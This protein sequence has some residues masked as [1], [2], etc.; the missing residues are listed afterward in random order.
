[1]RAVAFLA[2]LAGTALSAVPAGAQS[3]YDL[4]Y[5]RNAIY[6]SYGYCFRSSLGKRTFDNS[7]CH[8]RA[9]RLSPSDQRRVDSL[10]R[11]E[12]RRGC[13]VNR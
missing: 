7:D 3:C 8:T 5:E 1:M 12:R 6:D 9:P 4:W 10:R 2:A 13:K 11:E